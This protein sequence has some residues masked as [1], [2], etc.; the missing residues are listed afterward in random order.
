MC[1][2]CQTQV[3]EASHTLFTCS[4]AKTL[5]ADVGLQELSNFE[6]GMTVKDILIREFKVGARERW[7]KIRLFCWGLWTRRN[8]WVWNKKCISVFGIRS[9]AMVMF[10]D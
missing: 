2:W 1:A 10:Q 9:M 8:T 5:W 4:F 3:E 6:P 7:V